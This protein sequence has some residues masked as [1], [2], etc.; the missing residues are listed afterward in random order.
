MQRSGLVRHKAG[1][2]WFVGCMRLA[3]AQLFIAQPQGVAIV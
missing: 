2:F 3:L 1:K